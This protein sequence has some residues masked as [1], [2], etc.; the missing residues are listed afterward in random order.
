MREATGNAFIIMMVTSIIGIIMVFFVG[1]ISYSKSYR[2]KN[3][4]INIIQEKR[5]WD[6]S[7]QEIEEYMA[8]VGYNVR[9]NGTCPYDTKCH[10]A[11]NNQRTYNYCVYKCDDGNLT[12]YKVITYMKFEF[13]VINSIVQIPI[14]GETTTFGI[15]N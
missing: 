15:F 12:K 9:R 3:H 13:P 1:S 5:G 4:I 14:K 11:I 7:E 2:I 8:D 6:N 10:Q